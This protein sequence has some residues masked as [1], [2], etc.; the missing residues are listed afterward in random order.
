MNALH[1][2]SLEVPAGTLLGLLGPNGS[3]K[4]TLLS[5]LAGFIAPTSGAFRLLGQADHRQALAHTGTLISR[6][7]LW[8]H[9]SCRDNLRCLHSM[10]GHEA[11][12][13]QLELSLARVGLDG[14]AAGRKFGHCSTGM[15]QRLGIAAALIGNPDLLL[16]DEP[17]TGLDP[18]GMVEI[19]ELIKSLSQQQDRTIVMSS[20]LLHEVELTCDHYAIIHR[21]AVVDQ[22]AMREAGPPT[23]AMRITTTDNAAAIPCLQQAGWNV[24]PVPPV[25][26]CP[27]WLVVTAG[28]GEEWK[29]ARDLAGE[30]IYPSAMH[31][32]EGGKQ[33]GSL[34]QKYLDA[35]G[36]TASLLQ[37]SIRGGPCLG[38]F[39]GSCSACA[40]AVPSSFWLPWHYSFRR[41][42]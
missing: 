16:L 20:H 21:G 22:G 14:A 12:P 19:R 33:G 8:P 34:E 41:W 1:N 32:M 9:L 40:G 3:G 26:A 35:V 42:C 24:T 4:T 31:R 30:G 38:W 7:L 37:G 6:P 27:D 13:D 23:V 39:D 11:G 18:E 25:K 15:K 2:V 36:S 5:I 29:I 10:Y 28:P 17:T